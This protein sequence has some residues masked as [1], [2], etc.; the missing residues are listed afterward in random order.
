MFEQHEEFSTSPP[1]RVPFSTEASLSTS[2]YETT[3]SRFGA[4]KRPRSP[5]ETS[6]APAAPSGDSGR[7]LAPSR[8]ASAS[9]CLSAAALS[10]SRRVRLR[11]A[12]CA[13]RFVVVRECSRASSSRSRRCASRIASA[14]SRKKHSV[15][16]KKITHTANIIHP[17]AVS[18]LSEMRGTKARSAAGAANVMSKCAKTA[19]L[20]GPSAIPTA[21]AATNAPEARVRSRSET[22]SAMYRRFNARAPPRPQMKR[23]PRSIAS[24]QFQPPE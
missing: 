17:G 20:P 15:T 23:P 10:F 5:A 9:A 6:P 1:R 21:P 7:L 12:R 11:C 18:A 22:R 2:V 16:T 14:G 19:A 24:R 3:A 4:S 8:S 13:L